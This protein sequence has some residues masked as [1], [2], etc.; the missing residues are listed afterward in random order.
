MCAM[1]KRVLRYT[2]STAECSVCHIEKPKPDFSPDRRGSRGVHA[3]CRACTR[4]AATERRRMAGA[5]PMAEVCA[6]S[7]APERACTKCGKVKPNRREFFHPDARKAGSG[8][9]ARCR[10]CC[11]AWHR[12]AQGREV[13]R[14]VT[15]TDHARKRRAMAMRRWRAK[16]Q[17]AVKAHRAVA[18]AV[19]RGRLQRQP[20]EKCGA[21]NGEAHHHKGYAPEHHLDVEWLCK[22]CHVVEHFGLVPQ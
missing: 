11:R 3:M 4:A 21:P 6:A 12:S 22:E 14:A 2:E 17:D 7:R 8:L 15:K 10:E 18:H 16:S 9:Q 5:R 1:A 13:G 19:K 20:C